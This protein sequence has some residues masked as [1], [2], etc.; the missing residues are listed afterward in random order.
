MLAGVEILL[1]QR[2]GG[3]CRLCCPQSSSELSEGRQVELSSFTY[4]LSSW[5][6]F[7]SHF[8][9]P[10]FMSMLLSLFRQFMF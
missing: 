10:H 2:E 7:P 6:F 5:M 9:N 1:G 8:M 4:W 3:L